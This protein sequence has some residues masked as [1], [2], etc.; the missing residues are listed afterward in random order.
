MEKFGIDGD[1]AKKDLLA[2][3]N[4]QI[5]KDGILKRAPERYGKYPKLEIT[6]KNHITTRQL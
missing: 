4:G 5:L 2:I 3:I 6:K 1:S